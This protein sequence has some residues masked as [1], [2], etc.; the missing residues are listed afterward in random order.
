MF[1]FYVKRSKILRSSPDTK[2]ME[3]ITGPRGFPCEDKLWNKV[4]SIW[5][6]RRSPHH[7]QRRNAH[8][9]Q[10]APQNRSPAP[11][12]ERDGLRSPSVEKPSSSRNLCLTDEETEAAE[13]RGS[14]ASRPAQ[15]DF[16]CPTPAASP[17]PSDP[18][19]GETAVRV[20]L[21]FLSSRP[22]RCQAWRREAATRH[23]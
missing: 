13:G 20:S 3:N 17:P 11:K 6:V 16:H 8:S 18:E 1:F 22:L 14:D 7:P 5:K 9:C 19:Q 15:N 10:S 21:T 2:K 12:C 4:S 23:S